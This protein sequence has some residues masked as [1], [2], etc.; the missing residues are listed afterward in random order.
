MLDL[1]GPAVA[2]LAYAAEKDR[3]D[4]SSTVVADPNDPLPVTPGGVALL[5]GLSPDDPATLDVVR[6]AAAREFS[7]VVVK[8]RGRDL[9]RLLQE[10]RHGGVSLIVAAD[11]IPWRHLDGLLSTALSSAAADP[12]GSGEAGGDQLFSIANAVAAVAGGSVAIEDL[13]QHVLAYSSVAGQ[14][15]DELRRQ[16]ILDR[17]VPRGPLDAELYRRVMSAEGMVRFPEMDEDLPRAAIAIRA[18]NLPLGTLWAIEGESGISAEAERAILDGARLA[19]LHMLR[20]RSAPDLERLRR[21]EVLRALLEGTG[22]PELAW[23]RLGFRPGDRMALV[24][25]APSWSPEAQDAVLITHVAREVN[26][27]CTALR[28]EAPVATSTRAVYVLITGH[29]ASEAADRLARR[30]V[31]DASRALRGQVY[32]A[33]SSEGTGARLL[34]RLRDE[35]DQILR[36]NAGGLSAPAVAGMADVQSSVMLLHVRDELDRHPELQH[37]GLRQLLEHD[38]E[39]HGE[40]ALSLLVWLEAGQSVQS[41]AER[42]HVHPNTLRYRLRRVRQLAPIDL[43]DPDQRLATWLEL[44]LTGRVRLGRP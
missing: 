43:D 26:R 32:A 30:I 35:V 15:I 12:D 1:I 39:R 24:G 16:G 3:T 19:A 13:S 36:I 10:A 18:G 9:E 31:A 17:R 27:L 6:R 44:R 42:L 7:A 41:A 5:V 37:P 34:P 23:P 33:L 22:S 14:R 2:E 21:G 25:L 40:L 28:P 4:L 20:T 38:R 29:R 11:E 8:R